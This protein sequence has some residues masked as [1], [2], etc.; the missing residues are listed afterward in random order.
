MPCYNPI[1]SWLGRYVNPKTGKRPYVFRFQEALEPDDRRKLPCR[2]C[3]G[4]RLRR[5][6]E[7]AVR[8]MCEA[9][10]HEHSVFIT[11]T[12]S[13]E[14]LEKLGN[15]IGE[16]RHEDFAK[17]MKRLKSF[18]RRRQGSEA[19]KQIRFY[20]CGEYGEKFGRPHFHAAIFGWRPRDRKF[21]KKTKG[22]VLYTASDLEKL[23]KFGFHSF[24]K[25][26]FTTAS[27]ISRYIMKKR[28]G[29]V[30]PDHYERLNEFGEYVQVKPDY[31]QASRGKGL[32]RPWLER[33]HRDVYPK[34][35]FHLSGKRVRPPKFF[36]NVYELIDPEKM[37]E[38]KEARQ[39]VPKKDSSYAR[40]TEK[41][42][43]AKLDLRQAKRSLDYEI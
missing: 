39:M 3:V 16:L 24:G 20:M 13:D 23:W 29:D 5:S 19:A 28:V 31:Q 17:F 38:V 2:W 32:G 33:Y 9:Q 6:A 1:S 11:L 15:P 14:A 27:Y 22:G 42:I 43:Y 12:Y 4:C 37:E 41:E 8:A 7:W 10:C 21:L 36:D 35:Y 34:D 18:V 40:M 26:N 25:F 30:A